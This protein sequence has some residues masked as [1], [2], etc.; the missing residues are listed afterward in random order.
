[1][2]ENRISKVLNVSKLSTGLRRQIPPREAIS[3]P[4]FQRG[5][6]PEGLRHP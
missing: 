6:D 1:M 2:P 3:R 4:T 5:P